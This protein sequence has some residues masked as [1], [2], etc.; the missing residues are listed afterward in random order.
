M[1]SIDASM[2]KEDQ[3]CTAIKVVRE[4]LP[5]PKKVIMGK[6]NCNDLA[7]EL[8]CASILLPAIGRMHVSAHYDLTDLLK[9]ALGGAM[10]MIKQLGTEYESLSGLELSLA[11]ANLAAQALK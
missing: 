3:L 9:Q 2:T 11:I 4:V 6:Q 10:H 1:P 7:G 5:L 8:A